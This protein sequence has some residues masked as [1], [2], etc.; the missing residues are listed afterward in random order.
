VQEADAYVVGPLCQ[1]FL[2]QRFRLIT[3]VP[4]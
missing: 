1:Q 2:E 3:F 4:A